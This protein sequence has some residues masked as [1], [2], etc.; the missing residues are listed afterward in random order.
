M[1]PG[2]SPRGDEGA[3][4]AQRQ[5]RARGIGARGRWA[6]GARCVRGSRRAAGG[7]RRAYPRSGVRERGRGVQPAVG[8]RGCSWRAPPRDNRRPGRRGLPAQR[9]VL[10]CVS[11]HRPPECGGLHGAVARDN[12]HPRDGNRGVRL[13]GC[14]NFR[15]SV[16]GTRPSTTCGQ[17]AVGRRPAA[18][19]RVNSPRARRLHG[20]RPSRQPAPPV[21][22]RARGQRR[23]ARDGG[24]TAGFAA[25]ATR[26]AARAYRPETRSRGHSPTSDDP[27]QPALGGRGFTGSGPACHAAADA[28]GFTGQRPHAATRAAPGV[29]GH[30]QQVP[31]TRR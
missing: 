24:R 30:P 26:S 14:W 19:P 18:A 8:A 25:A 28:R 16:G 23:H 13:C 2:R 21:E 15:G 31:R 11:T 17:R 3:H 29:E 20:R 1:S 7:V 10:P 9:G 6:R 12:R 5:G 22:V 27:C 4:D